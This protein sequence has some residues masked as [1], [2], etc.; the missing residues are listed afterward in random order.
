V[1]SENECPRKPKESAQVKKK[2]STTVASGTTHVVDTLQASSAPALPRS[3]FGAT[4]PR[5]SGLTPSQQASWSGAPSS[6][7]AL[8]P[9]RSSCGAQMPHPSV[10]P[11]LL[12]QLGRMART[13]GGAL[14]TPSNGAPMP[15]RG[16]SSVPMT[17]SSSAPMP[18]RGSCGAPMPSGILSGARLARGSGG[19]L[20]PRPVSGLPSRLQVCCTAAVLVGRVARASCS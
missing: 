5:L 19:S 13:S 1:Q 17:P 7:G 6:G 20:I 18:P 8:A 14:M 4:M 15:P 3:S 10:P 9:P 16:S 2:V 11:P 12:Q